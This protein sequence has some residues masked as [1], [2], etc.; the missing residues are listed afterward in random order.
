MWARHFILDSEFMSALSGNDD[1]K[2]NCQLGYRQN[3]THALSITADYS[4]TQLGGSLV[5][6]DSVEDTC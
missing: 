6:C 5:K 4:Y 2:T 3:Y 1:R